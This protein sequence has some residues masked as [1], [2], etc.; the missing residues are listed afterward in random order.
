ML[1]AEPNRVSIVLHDD[2][3]ERVSGHCHGVPDQERIKVLRDL[4]M[5]SHCED[6]CCFEQISERD[7]IAEPDGLGGDSTISLYIDPLPPRQIATT[8][9]QGRRLVLI[10][11]GATR[12]GKDRNR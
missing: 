1:I 3:D 12:V 9:L 8:Y 6:N 10:T 2:V 4:G 5:I 7:R 11:C